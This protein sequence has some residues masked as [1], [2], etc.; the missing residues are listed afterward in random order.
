MRH[1]TDDYRRQASTG[2]VTGICIGLVLTLAV[3]LAAVIVG[4]LCIIEGAGS[5]LW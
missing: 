4:H 5:C 2:F 3:G 1:L